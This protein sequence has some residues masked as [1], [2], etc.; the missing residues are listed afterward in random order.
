MPRPKV[1]A[2]PPKSSKPIAGDRP[3]DDYNAKSSWS[4]VLVGWTELYTKGGLTYWTRPGKKF[5]ISATTGLRPCGSDLLHVFTSSTEF[6]EGKN[7]DKFGAYT[8]LNHS[9]D[10][11]EAAKALGRAGY[12]AKR[13]KDAADRAERTSRGEKKTKPKAPIDPAEPKYRDE[14]GCIEWWSQGEWISARQLHR[15]HHQ[16][17]GDRRRCRGD[18]RVRDHGE[19]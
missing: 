17:G 3:G 6:D 12:G 1:G 13:V 16:A 9:G 5:G 11:T 14:N 2:Q 15:A 8:L 10:F 7:Y 19:A 18:A 4:E